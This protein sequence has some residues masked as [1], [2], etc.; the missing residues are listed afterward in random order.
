MV[1]HHP[2]DLRSLN[3]CHRG[4]AASFAGAVDTSPERKRNANGDGQ[5]DPKEDDGFGLLGHGALAAKQ[6]W[7]LSST[8]PTRS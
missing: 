3:H 7:T 2:S 1:V 5:A 4:I 8:L 6:P